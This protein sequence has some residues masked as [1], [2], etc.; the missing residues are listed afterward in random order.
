MMNEAN[1]TIALVSIHFLFI[2]CCIVIAVDLL[3]N[4]HLGISRESLM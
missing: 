2:S 3:L 1:R 4:K